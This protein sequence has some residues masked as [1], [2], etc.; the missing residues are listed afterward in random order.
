MFARD[1][2][3]TY[4]TL[5]I[6]VGLGG[7][8]EGDLVQSDGQVEDHALPDGDGALGVEDEVGIAEVQPDAEANVL[9]KAADEVLPSLLLELLD[10]GTVHLLDLVSRLHGL[11]AGL[12]RGEEGLVRVGNGLGRVDE[13]GPGDVAAV[14]Q[15]ARPEGHRDDV[16]LEGLVG[17]LGRNLDVVLP[18]AL[19]DGE[20]ARA[21]L[22]LGD[23]ELDLGGVLDD[24]VDLGG[25]LLVRDRLL[26]VDDVLEALDDAVLHHLVAEDGGL[27]QHVE[28]GRVLDG[29]DEADAGSDVDGLDVVGIVDL[30][31]PRGEDGAAAAFLVAPLLP[32]DADLPLAVAV[33]GGRVLVETGLLEQ[34]GVV[35]GV[36]IGLV[37]AQE[38]E[39]GDAAA[40]GDV[41]LGRT[42]ELA[43]LLG[44]KDD[45]LPVDGKD[46]DGIGQLIPEQVLVEARRLEVGVV[47]VNLAAVQ[48]EAVGTAPCV[49]LAVRL[50]VQ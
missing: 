32:E 48:H 37:A 3:V 25:Q 11:E 20:V 21:D 41:L 17:R 5:G 24:G 12:L 8:A 26:L 38:G 18:A 14:L 46:Q 31:L 28:L 42:E 1:S 2:N 33:G 45:A 23:V 35:L 30:L 9:G 29:H 43:L 13:E 10:G 22:F 15:V 7:I 19:D 27:L 49:D 40:L 50:M 47:L 36:V 44:G 39:A 34:S 4:L 16:V 6:A